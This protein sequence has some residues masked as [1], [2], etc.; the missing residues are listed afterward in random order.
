MY[1]PDADADAGQGSQNAEAEA[2]GLLLNMLHGLLLNPKGAPITSFLPPS[3]PTLLLQIEMC[4]EGS[5]VRECGGKRRSGGDAAVTKRHFWVVVYVDA[6]FAAVWRHVREIYA[7]LVLQLTTAA[8]DLPIAATET[9]A[10][11]GLQWGQTLLVQGRSLH[12]TATTHAPPMP[13][14]AI[15]LRNVLSRCL[16]AARIVWDGAPRFPLAKLFELR[17][18]LARDSPH[19]TGAAL[20]H[21]HSRVVLH[22]LLDRLDELSVPRNCRSRRAA[23]IAALLA[24]AGFEAQCRDVW[25]RRPREP[26]PAPLLLWLRRACARLARLPHKLS[27]AKRYLRQGHLAELEAVLSELSCLEAAYGER[28]SDESER[29]IVEAIV[30]RLGHSWPP[31]AA[32]YVQAWLK[33]PDAPLDVPRL[34]AAGYLNEVRLCGSMLAA[35]GAGAEASSEILDA[36][37]QGMCLAAREDRRVVFMRMACVAAEEGLFCTYSNASFW[38]G[39]YGSSLMGVVYGHVPYNATGFGRAFDKSCLA[40]PL[41]MLIDGFFNEGALFDDAFWNPISVEYAVRCFGASPLFA[42]EGSPKPFLATSF[43]FN[44]L[45][46]VPLPCVSVPVYALHMARQT[47]SHEIILF[48]AEDIYVQQT[49]VSVSAWAHDCHRRKAKSPVNGVPIIHPEA[50]QVLDDIG[51]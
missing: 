44:E 10:T 6:P 21:Y 38:V 8:G 28:A 14:R 36:Y 17:G 34:Q 15:V 32:E 39:G 1:G 9:P 49:F 51:I 3:R 19:L 40:Q 18:R 35:E 29:P 31:F 13:D 45:P 41:S 48:G 12:G 37:L 22:L 27:D 24:D 33:A 7:V 16:R 4:V 30:V 47:H 43:Y 5:Y 11:H 26:L 50:L 46:R 42:L 23:A 2:S 25:T 20:N